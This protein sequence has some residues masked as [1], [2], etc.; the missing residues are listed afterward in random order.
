MCVPSFS[1]GFQRHLLCPTSNALLLSTELLSRLS[2]SLLCSACIALCVGTE[3][4]SRLPRHHPCSISNALLVST[5]LLSRFSRHLSISLH[6]SFVRTEQLSRLLRFMLCYP[7]R[8]GFSKASVSWFKPILK[9]SARPQQGTLPFV[10]KFLSRAMQGKASTS[11]PLHHSFN[12]TRYRKTT[13]MHP[14]PPNIT[15]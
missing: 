1:Q 15:T 10:Q 5:E 2:R 9:G 8:E 4:L 6:R 3:L 14:P 13:D 11:A 7:Q 12:Q